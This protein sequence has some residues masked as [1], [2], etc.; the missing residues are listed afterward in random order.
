MSLTLHLGVIDVPYATEQGTTTGDVA[1]YLEKKYDLMQNFFDANGQRVA[2]LMAEDVTNEI[3]NIMNGLAPRTEIFG[4]S[5]GEIET[6]FKRD[7]IEG[8]G[9][10]K[11]GIVG[12]PTKAALKGVN[13]RLKIKRGKR[14]PSFRDTGEFEA[15][16]KAWITE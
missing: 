16:F 14:R 15:S 12:T 13:H 7:F 5:M 4:D 1:G 3:D 8:Q 6:M 11:L 10:E 9:S 2:D